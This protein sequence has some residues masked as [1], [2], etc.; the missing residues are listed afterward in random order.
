[1]YRLR[2]STKPVHFL[3]KLPRMCFSTSVS[4]RS[5]SVESFLNGPSASYIEDMYASWLQDPKSVHVSWQIYFKNLRSGANAPAFTAPPTIIPTPEIVG[6]IPSLDSAVSELA[7]SVPS[8]KVLEHM[9]V[10]LMVR[11][12]QVK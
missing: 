12:Y 10:Q 4:F 7:T 6:N 1:M 5:N 3:N 8:A 11:A 9:K 2:V